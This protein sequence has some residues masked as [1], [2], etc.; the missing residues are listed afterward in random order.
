MLPVILVPIALPGN[1]QQNGRP[2]C[3]R[4]SSGHMFQRFLVT[5]LR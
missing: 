5:F 2:Q 4:G 3:R 1:S